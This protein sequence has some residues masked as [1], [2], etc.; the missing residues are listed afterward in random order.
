MPASRARP[1]H[2]HG[3]RG[4]RGTFGRVGHGHRGRDEERTSDIRRRRERACGR[5]TVLEQLRRAECRELVGLGGRRPDRGTAHRIGPRGDEDEDR[6]RAAGLAADARHEVRDLA[7]RCG[8]RERRGEDRE[9]MRLA[10][11]ATPSRL[12]LV[13]CGQ[14]RPRWI[15]DAAD[16]RAEAGAR[17]D[18][19]HLQRDDAVR[20]RRPEA[21]P[22]RAHGLERGVDAREDDR[23]ERGCETAAQTQ[24]PRGEERR[25][26]RQ[27]VPAAQQH[28]GVEQ[29]AGQMRRE[30][31][32]HDD[33]EPRETPTQSRG[34][35]LGVSPPG[36]HPG[37]GPPSRE[38]SG[39]SY[40]SDSGSTSTLHGAGGPSPSSAPGS[41]PAK[42]DVEP[43]P[44]GAS[45]DVRGRGTRHQRPVTPRSA[46][47]A[48]SRS[49]I[50]SASRSAAS[51]S[52]S[53][54]VSLTSRPN[55]GEPNRSRS[56]SSSS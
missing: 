45:G 9:V 20:E 54:T 6:I 32:A 36:A 25:G 53:A 51:R 3:G 30:G 2:P 19:Q 42:D 52:G 5:A 48:R 11:R 44:V 26:E 35:Q 18:G 50:A 13:E 38:S 37:T 34:H 41:R 7:R 1:D 29:R 43:P 24:E 16:D 10:L 12:G 55:G 8:S 33:R 49:A 56:A 22:G 4:R 31:Q 15:A 28:E 21:V 23:D 40:R 39:V 46:A 17:D 27:D 14:E 47:S